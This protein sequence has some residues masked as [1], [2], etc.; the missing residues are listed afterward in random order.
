[1]FDTEE[2]AAP[3]LDPAVFDRLAASLAN[4]GPAVAIEELCSRLR[5]LGDFDALFYALLMKRRVELGVS[6]FPTGSA[7]DLPAETHE[8]YEQAIRDAGRLVGGLY[9]IQGDI[10]RA[11]F[12]YNMLGEIE[13]VRDYIQN[14]QP[15][16]DADPQPVIEVALYNGVDPV[17]GFGL[18]LERY[19]ICNAIT[20][21]SQY[22]FSR[23]PR[24]KPECIKLLVRSLHDQLLERLRSDIVMRGD[25]Y[26]QTGSI[27]ELLND[28]NYLLAEDAYH[29]DTSHLSSVVQMSL[30]LTDGVE[31]ML[32]RELCAYGERLSPQFHQEADT[33]F[34]RTYADY[35]ILLEVTAGVHVE[36]GLKHF[37]D[38]IEPAIEQGSTFPAEVFVNLLSRIGRK[39]EAIEVAKKYLSGVTRPMSCP[40]VYDMCHEAKDYQGLA[41]AAKSRADGV[42]YLASLI[43]SR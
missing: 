6:P 41:N 24:A 29:I 42:N 38:K 9:L 13:P 8:A 37:R 32:A 7:A 35:K 1:M 25:T 12:F 4:Q 3:T 28:R 40:G 21:F 26:P 39:K 18:V 34:E 27:I 16:A 23:N 20:T 36:K 5:E 43:A 31:V 10:R 17:R 19:G 2:Q 15:D 22:D 33:P 14:Y 11:W 30:E